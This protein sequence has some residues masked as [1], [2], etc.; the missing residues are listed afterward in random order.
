MAIM[1]V[2]WNLLCVDLMDDGGVRNSD[3]VVDTTI[4]SANTSPSA[5]VR[6]R[7]AAALLRSIPKKYQG[8]IDEVVEPGSPLTRQN[9][10]DEAAFELFLAANDECSGWCLK[11]E[12]AGPYDEVILGEL[13]STLWDFFNPHGEPLFSLAAI[14]RYA[15]FGPGSAPGLK[16]R[17]SFVEKLGGSILT[18]SSPL[19]IDLFY[20][21]VGSRE[22]RLDC[23]VARALLFGEPEVMEAC[24]ITPVP[25]NAKISRLVKPEPLLNMFFQKGVQHLMEQRLKAYFGIDL[26]EQDGVN[27]ELARI[28][29]LGGGFSTIDLSSASDYIAHKLCAWMLPRSVMNWLN[30]FRSKHAVVGVGGKEI[31]LH[32]MATMGNAFCFPLQTI[33]FASVVAAV[34]KA[35]G[36]PLR[37]SSKEPVYEFH[38]N[39]ADE[40]MS[41]VR[42]KPPV[43]FGVFGDDIVVVDEAF[44]SVVRAL[45]LLGQH[46]NMEKSFG[47]NDGSFRESCGSDWYEGANI[48][49][50]YVKTLDTK[51]DFYVLINSLVAWSARTG[52]KLPLTVQWLVDHVR[53]VEVPPWENPD[54]GI[55]VPLSSVQTKNVLRAANRPDTEEW[56]KRPNYQGSYVYKAYNAVT[57][58]KDVSDEVAA[59]SNGYL[60]PSALLIAASRGVIRGG[61]VVE[62]ANKSPPYCLQW[63]VA[64]SWDH[65]PFGDERKSF[66]QA[67]Y[68]FANGYFYR[69]SN[70]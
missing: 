61:R 45:K 48:R 42:S 12:H 28:G 39:E 65:I 66:E 54:A 10:A 15:D 69:S 37:R 46:P 64:P 29:S 33:F 50:V 6:T 70:P 62:R 52:I 25:K 26:S 3:L 55:R 23:E 56:L 60:N 21:W 2:L 47:P 1:S 19:I 59:V 13:R 36:I 30:L 67:W 34:Y 18:A 38:R 20:Q 51:Q 57:I 5:N 24:N 63:R 68:K 16:R 53:R 40:V 43:N 31:E 58:G 17:T 22:S 4:R 32:M 35:L 14:E 49:G 9:V 11:E 41:I 27:A 7:A 8:E 44:G